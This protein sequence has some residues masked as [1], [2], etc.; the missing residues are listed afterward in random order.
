MKLSPI[1]ILLLLILIVTVSV[2]AGRNR[3]EN[4]LVVYSR[5]VDTHGSFQLGDPI[6][7]Q[8]ESF[9]GTSTASPMPKPAAMPATNMKP[10][11]VAKPVPILS[12]AANGSPMA[13]AI[14]TVVPTPLTPS[15]IAPLGKAPSATVVPVTST[16]YDAMSLK[17]KSD[18]LKE[19]QTLVRNELL[20]NR[21]LKHPNS[22]C[23]EEEEYAECDS[24]YANRQGKEFNHHSNKP[25]EESH[26]PPPPD[27]SNYIRKDQIP[28]WGCSVDY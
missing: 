15:A 7:L 4:E 12:P 21:Q 26:C 11:P 9:V 19:V 17:Q 5:G 8:E 1:K 23:E 18:L 2:Y 13:A 6:M 10:V 28:C 14:T 25:S 27:L 24:S 20:T 16:A 3:F 22:S